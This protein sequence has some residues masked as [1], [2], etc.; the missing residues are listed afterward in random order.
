VGVSVDLFT[1]HGFTPQYDGI[2]ADIVHGFFIGAAAFS[3]G[4]GQRDQQS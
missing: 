2:L 4:D 3:A 1:A